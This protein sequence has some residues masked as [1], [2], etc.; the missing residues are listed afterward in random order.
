[1]LLY[2]RETLLAWR[3]TVISIWRNKEIG[4]SARGCRI[5]GILKIE[6]RWLLLVFREQAS[7]FVNTTSY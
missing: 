7:L 4:L 2:G 1:M 3:S 6:R 5:Q